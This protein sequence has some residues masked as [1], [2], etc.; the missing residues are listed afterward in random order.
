MIQASNLLLSQI[1]T[2]FFVV[3]DNTFEFP[4]PPLDARQP[5]HLHV[6]FLKQYLV[7]LFPF[8]NRKPDMGGICSFLPEI[9][10]FCSLI[11]L[12]ECFR[13]HGQAG[14]SKCA[15]VFQKDCTTVYTT[16][17][18]FLKYYCEQSLVLRIRIFLSRHARSESCLTNYSG[19]KT[20]PSKQCLKCTQ[21][22]VSKAFSGS[23]F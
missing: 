23:Y 21:Q 15:F 3:A 8:L 20:Q 12:H 19:S 1:L 9:P 13:I 5:L 2:N 22:D 17:V 6:I 7:Y 4:S 11:E 18:R 14:R 10:P 16:S